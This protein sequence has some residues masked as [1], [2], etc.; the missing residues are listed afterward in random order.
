MPAALSA[1]LRRELRLA[2]GVFVLV[3]LAF[4]V[5]DRGD[6]ADRLIGDGGDGLQFLWNVWWIEQS[7]FQGRNPYFT[8]VV[9]APFGTPL[10][11]HSLAPLPSALI[12][13]LHQALDVRLAHNLVV[14]GAFPLAGLGGF[15]LCRYVTRDFRA[16]VV[17]GLVFMLCPFLASKTLGHLN[18]L[19]GGLLPFFVVALWAATEPDGPRPGARSALA[20]ASLA[21]VLCNVHTAIFAANVA[22]WTWLWRCQ[23]PRGGLAATRRFFRA[24]TPA[25]LLTAPWALTLVGYGLAY[26]WFPDAGSSTGQNPGLRS[27]VLP[28]TP[29][30]LWSGW[31]GRVSE[32]WPMAG[33]LELACYLG[34]LVF[35]LCV[36]GM[37]LRWRDARV[38]F[39]AFLLGL[40]LMFSFGPVL[41]HSGEAVL[42]DGTPVALPFALWRRVPVLGGVY[43]TGR[44]L[45]IG[46]AMMAIGMAS[47]VVALRERWGVRPAR[48][49]AFA[50]GAVVCV[51][52]AF[53]P[54][55]SKLPEV[56]ELAGEGGLVLEARHANSH[57]MYY[58][59]R[60]ERPMMGGYLSRPP[61]FV[62]ERYRQ[63]PGVG[64]FFA[65]APG[66]ATT[67]EELVGGLVAAGVTNVLLS[68]DDPRGETLAGFG[69]RAHWQDRRVVVWEVPGG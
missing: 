61:S 49:A 52:Y 51:D 45:L 64:W 67:R 16:S 68:P 24:V 21:I 56:P 58:Q 57:S 34:I 10:V 12:G 66:S 36:A 50:L 65:A 55:F 47:L 41:L 6:L 44:Y 9:F 15:L 28:Y 53:D 31:A 69:F 37:M 60:H 22:L 43:Q 8:D 19:F 40:H 48:R 42:L 35:P 25:L 20:L 46:Y 17:G 23:G 18:L 1:Q 4:Y 30:S 5:P 59:T 62:L 13:L 39:A 26:D 54:R 7:L 27:F 32:P 14:M 29:T 11:W 33:H 38:R 63:T 3:T 2:A